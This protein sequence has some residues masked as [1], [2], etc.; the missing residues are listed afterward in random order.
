MDFEGRVQGQAGPL[1][2]A[3]VAEDQG[4]AHLVNPGVNQG[5]DDDLGP[6]PHRVAHG[7]GQNGSNG[8]FGHRLLIPFRFD[9]LH[10]DVNLDPL[11]G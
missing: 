8:R 3:Q 10:L 6:H 11:G 9:P 2:G 5:L 7:Q 1:Q 4:P